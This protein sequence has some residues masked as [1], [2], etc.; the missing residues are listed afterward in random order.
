MFSSVVNT[1][2]GISGIHSSGI[3]SV[4]K[5]INVQSSGVNS[6]DHYIPEDHTGPG[7]NV[8]PGAVKVPTSTSKKGKFP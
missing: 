8:A 6:R 1:V 3:S 4:N 2:N 7:F 5:G